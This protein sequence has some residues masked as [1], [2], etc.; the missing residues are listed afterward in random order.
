VSRAGVCRQLHLDP[1]TVR[2]YADASTVEEL[3]VNT[4]RDSLIDPYRPY[5]HQR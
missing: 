2:R 3:L 1:H 4:R 5:L